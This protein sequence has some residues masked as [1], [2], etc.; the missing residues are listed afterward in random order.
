MQNPKTKDAAKILAKMPSKGKTLLIAL[1]EYNKNTVLSARNIEKTKV[2]ETRNLN[3]LDILNA[4]YLLLTKD[5]IKKIKE[6][7]AK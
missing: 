6:I 5:G 4:K 2:K 7:F 1:P 3:V